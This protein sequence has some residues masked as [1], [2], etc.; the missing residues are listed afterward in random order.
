MSRIAQSL[1]KC[2]IISPKALFYLL[3]QL[4][5]NYITLGG[6][7]FKEYHLIAQ[8]LLGFRV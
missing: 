2:T 7:G 3:S 6:G 8:S 4:H 1:Y 5:C